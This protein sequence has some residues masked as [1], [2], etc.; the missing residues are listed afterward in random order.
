MISLVMRVLEMHKQVS[1]EVE[2]FTH[3]MNC[4]GTVPSISLPR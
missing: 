1:Q 2:S 4:Y 3:G